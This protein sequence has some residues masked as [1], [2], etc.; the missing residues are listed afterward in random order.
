MISSF[1]EVTTL[2]L[3]SGLY[4]WIKLVVFIIYK[5]PAFEKRLLKAK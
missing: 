5:P 3:F 1:L 2:S 4:I